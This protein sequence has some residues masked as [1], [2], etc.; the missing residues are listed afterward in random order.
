MHEVTK[1]KQAPHD[2]DVLSTCA[3]RPDGF[4]LASGSG[5][6]TLRV[7]DVNTWRLGGGYTHSL[8]SS[9]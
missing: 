1:L 8:S 7:W 5:D 3:W 2:A 9:T 4:M 6:L